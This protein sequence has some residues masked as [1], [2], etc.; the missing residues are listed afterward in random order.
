MAKVRRKQPKVDPERRAEIMR[1]IED[2]PR[3]QATPVRRRAIRPASKQ[4]ARKVFVAYPFR[5]PSEDYRRPFRELEKA[6]K[7]KFEFADEKITNSHLLNKVTG[8]I[9]SSLFSLFD[10]TTW[11][12]NVTLELGIAVGGQRRYFLLFN[13][14]EGEED[15]PSDLGG[16][17]R[18][19][20]T[21]YTE[22]GERLSELLIQELGV[23]KEEPSGQEQME[24]LRKAV[25]EKVAK[26]DGP[27]IRH[28]A[29]S[30]GIPIELA[31]AIVR[32]MVEAGELRTTG[33]TRAR[34]YWLP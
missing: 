10:I 27:K 12:A 22:L 29:S 6:F 30:I 25:R 19:E 1:V 24:S 14:Q 34:Q 16:I 26:R 3:R 5:F 9:E 31:K 11:N 4:L 20:Y 32:Q 13:P 21:S 17:D 23:P 18:I 8:M 15:V 7:V 28:I 33:Q 2:S